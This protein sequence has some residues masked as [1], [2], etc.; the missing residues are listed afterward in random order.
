MLVCCFTPIFLSNNDLQQCTKHTSRQP[1]TPT[2]DVVASGLFRAVHS[3]SPMMHGASMVMLQNTSLSSIML[4]QQASCQRGRK[5]LFGQISRVGERE[6]L[7]SSGTITRCVVGVTTRFFEASH[8]RGY[9]P[10]NNGVTIDGR[11]QNE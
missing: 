9:T 3:P 8:V 6:L 2:T 11:C 1:E 7:K 4:V 5:C 10:P